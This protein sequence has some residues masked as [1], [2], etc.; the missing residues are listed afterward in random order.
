MNKLLEI[1]EKI[2]SQINEFDSFIKNYNQVTHT[3]QIPTMAY[4]NWGIN[5]AQKGKL[6][7]AI[8]KFQTAS[9]MVN[10]NPGV[11]LNLGIALLQ[12]KDY[13]G[14]IK[15]FRQ[16]VKLDKYNSKAYT[17]WAS[18][19]G[20]I[21]DIKGAID[22][23]KT[24]EKYDPRDADIYMNWGITLAKSNDTAQAKDKFKKSM[25]LNPIN[26]IVPFL[27]GLILFEEGNYIEAINRFNHSFLYSEDKY[28]SLYYLSL[29]YLRESNYTLAQRY[30]ID[31][32]SRDKSRIEAYMVMADCYIHTAQQDKCLEIFKTAEENADTDD[33]FYANWGQ[34]LQQYGFL[35]EAREKL[36]KALNLNPTS[37]V[38]LFNLGMNFLLCKEYT[39]AEEFFNNV[40]EKNS[41]HTLALYNMATLKYNK[42][43]YRTALELYKKTFDSDKRNHKVYINIANCFYK[44]KDYDNARKYYKKCIE[45][46]PDF[47]QGYINYANLLLEIGDKQE[48]QRKARTAYF[49]DKK[50][51]YAN[52]AYGVV[53]LKSEMYKEA[54]DKFNVTIE[55][56]STYALAY[57][58]KI[59][60][61]YCMNMYDKAFEILTDV[62]SYSESVPEYL[63]LMYKICDDVL[64]NKDI[65]KNILEISL[66]YCNKFLELYNNDKVNDIKQNLI[67]RLESEA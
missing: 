62:I 29:C 36:H 26:P 23:Y 54:L 17:M 58:G 41:E 12:K 52:F 48:A 25:S 3:Y 64:Q 24:A 46:C 20:E 51:P 59:E 22:I 31:A 32:I 4:M 9:L 63:T 60:A 61:L 34:T 14:A 37:E 19:L 42:D 8:E 2:F 50:S 30:A 21:G 67:I 43:D 18:A 33:S 35:D 11:Y 53:L 49:V 55:L 28:D 65:S 1:K 27:W 56:D 13:E 16:A 5:L 45:Y 10:T 66:Q 57:L 15:N 44:I 39:Q 47:I 6:E 7:E 38:V 40:L